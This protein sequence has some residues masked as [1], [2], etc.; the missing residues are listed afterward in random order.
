MALLCYNEHMSNNQYANLIFVKLGGSLITDKT[1]PRTPR[2]D[3]IARLATEIQTARSQF[4]DLKLVLGH[5]SGSYGHVVANK[6]GTRQGV[7]SPDG[8]RG[9]A[10]V[11]YEAATLN[12]IILQALH[13]TGL[14]GISFPP[15]GAIIAKDGQA[16]DWNLAPL[17]KALQFG[18]LPVVYGDVVFDQDRG[19][20]I[21]STEDVFVHLAG[22]LQPKRI[23][24]AGVDEGVWEDFPDCTRLV[25]EINM[26]NWRKVTAGLSGSSSTDVTGGMQ[27]K[28]RAM[29][30]LVRENP[31]MQVI[32]FNGRTPGN[33]LAA[34]RG[35]SLGTRIIKHPI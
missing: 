4:E 17:K 6:Y 13:E 12:R 31:E 1:Q 20:T 15:S 32:I 30:D 21:L 2:L 28:V 16:V 3:L 25:S 7:G 11:W 9:F 27:S 8:W 19:G 14:P 18:L 29:L 24:L 5:G 10:E 35:E 23:L 34:I 22:Q 33:L 26:E